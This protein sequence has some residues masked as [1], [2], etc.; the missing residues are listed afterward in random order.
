MT[1]LPFALWIVAL[2][3]AL[4]TY[5]FA[6]TANGFALG[7]SGPHAPWT[8]WLAQPSIYALIAPGA[9]VAAWRGVSHARRAEASRSSWW[10]LAAEGAI[11]GGLLAPA[12][13][14]V[15]RGSASDAGLASLQAAFLCG[16][17]G[18]VLAVINHVLSRMLTPPRAAA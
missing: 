18:F 11:A 14:V 3:D 6:F 17:L 4:A 10:Q 15:A 1:L 8:Y 5:A 9:L 12:L 2:V 7:R 16:V 13:V